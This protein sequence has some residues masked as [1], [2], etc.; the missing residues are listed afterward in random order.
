MDF[1]NQNGLIDTIYFYMWDK[2]KIKDSQLKP[3]MIQ[4]PDTIIFK[5]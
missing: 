5:N 3:F 1:Y 4:I 2:G